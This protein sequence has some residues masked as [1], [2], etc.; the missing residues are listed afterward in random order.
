MEAGCREGFIVG[1]R[2]LGY[3]VYRCR[4]VE[5]AGG[6]GAGFRVVRM[7]NSTRSE[8]ITTYNFILI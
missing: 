1:F 7:F 3:R 6:P 5:V 2:V 8:V 4:T